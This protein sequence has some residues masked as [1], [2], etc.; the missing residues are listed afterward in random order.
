MGKLYLT[1]LLPLLGEQRHSDE[2]DLTR[3][4]TDHVIYRSKKIGYT[5]D[6]PRDALRQSKPCQL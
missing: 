4:R 2:K 1:L 5:A 6:G 3:G